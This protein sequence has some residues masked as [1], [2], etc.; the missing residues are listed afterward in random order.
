MRKLTV[1]KKVIPDL[2]K[3]RITFVSRK[4]VQVC[5]QLPIGSRQTT[6]QRVPLPL[7]VCQRLGLIWSG[8]RPDTSCLRGWCRGVGGTG[9]STG[10]KF[11]EVEE[12]GRNNNDRVM[13]R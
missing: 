3:I 10:F 5:A 7:D 9:L 11:S 6:G 2:E 12:Q 8:C 4:H 1:Q 13:K